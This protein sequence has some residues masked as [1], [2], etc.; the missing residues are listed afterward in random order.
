MSRNKTESHSPARR[1]LL[2]QL[3]GLTAYGLVPGISTL[4]S[5]QTAEAA[6]SYQALVCVF[7]FGGNDGNNMIVPTDPTNYA[8]YLASRGGILGTPTN[9]TLALPNAGVTGGVLQLAPLNSQT[10]N[11]GL[12]PNMPELQALWS[13]GNVALLF[14]VGNLKQPFANAAAFLANKNAN[15][16]PQ[17]LYSHSDQQRQMQVTS[18]NAIGT[19]GWAG[20]LADSISTPVGTGTIPV[21]V[22]A[23]GNAMFL[24]GA[25]SS[26]IVVPQKG[27]LSYKGFNSTASSQARLA[28][29]KTMYGSGPDSLLVQTLGGA[30]NN[31]LNKADT[32]SNILSATAA[33]TLSGN[34]PN[35][36]TSGLSQQLTQVALMIQAAATGAISAPAKQIFFVDLNG[37]DTHNDQLNRQAPLLADLSSSMNGFYQAMVSIGQHN[38]VVAFTLSDFAR[39]LKPASGNGSDHAWG[40]HH[41]IVGGTGAIKGGTYGT[42]P[43]L[44]LGGPSDVSDEGRWMPTTSVDQYGATLANWLG[45]SSTAINSAFPNLTNFSTGNLG[46]L[47]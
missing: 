7:L 12:H 27:T 3:G 38:N 46:F 5:T 21:G 26:P 25:N 29:L 45:I 6:G 18:L 20:R 2:R 11:Y 47:T 34:F 13:T 22:S 8:T 32:L 19:T 30:Q 4:L 24:L 39:T 16:V 28:A 15:L 14:N 43:N 36:A 35:Y 17:N 41:I 37:F 9:G 33:A 10:Y 1:R 40:S 44:T 31:S 42:F 23:A